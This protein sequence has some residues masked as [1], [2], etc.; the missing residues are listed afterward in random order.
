MEK[1][2]EK[3]LIVGD[4]EE[5]IT[6]EEEEEEDQIMGLAL[7]ERRNFQRKE[8]FYL[9]RKEDEIGRRG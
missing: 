9:Q 8:D 3:L 1:E 6:E 5:K 7:E 4:E 2:M